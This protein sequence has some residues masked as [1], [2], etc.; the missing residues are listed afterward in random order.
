MSCRI[1]SCSWSCDDATSLSQASRIEVEMDS[2]KFCRLSSRFLKAA[3]CELTPDRLKSR[4]VFR[5]P[6]L[7]F[8]ERRRTHD[9][10]SRTS[11]A[12]EDNIRDTRN[13]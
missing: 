12:P 3:S 6:F 10:Q 5:A 8:L 13:W 11:Q 9:G 1:G 2:I 4:H 7:S